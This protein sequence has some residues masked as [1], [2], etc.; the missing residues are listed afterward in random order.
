[1]QCV[2]IQ[3]ELLGSP[4]ARQCSVWGDSEGASWVTEC[5]AVQD[6]EAELN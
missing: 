4:I 3:R 2:E 5:K 1:M 6:F